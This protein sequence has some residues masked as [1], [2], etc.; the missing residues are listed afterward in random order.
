MMSLLKVSAPDLRSVGAIGSTLWVLESTG[1]SS[2]GNTL[3]VKATYTLPGDPEGLRYAVWPYNTASQTYE[4]SLNARLALNGLNVSDVDVMSALSVGPEAQR[5]TIAEYV[6]S[7]PSFGPRLALIR[8]NSVVHDI[9]SLLDLDGVITAERY[10]VSADGRFLAVQT[11]D[12]GLAPDRSPDTNQS[13]DIYLLDLKTLKT[14]R[15][16]FVANLEANLP[17]TLANVVVSENQV[18]VSFSTAAAFSRADKNDSSLAPNDAYLW[19]RTFD[20]SGFSGVAGF[21]LISADS[22]N[23]AAGAVPVLTN[24]DWSTG[25]D[26]THMPIASTEGVWFE[27]SADSLVVGDDNAASDI[28]FVPTPVVSRSA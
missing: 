25:V 23:L 24:S 27:S 11:S 17:V 5:L 4:G 10:A 26:L 14:E 3:L 15:V 9:W 16:S 1:F 22:A 19:S 28:F 8:D 18:R 21:A 2:D 20:D 13:S 6:T 12:S 7:D